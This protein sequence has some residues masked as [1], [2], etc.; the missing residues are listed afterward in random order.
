MRLFHEKAWP[1]AII[2]TFIL[3]FYTFSFAQTESIRGVKFK[4]GS[5]IYGRVIKMNIYDIHIKTKNGKIIS[6]K[7][8]DVDIFIKIPTWMQNRNLNK[9]LPDT[10][11]STPLQPKPHDADVAQ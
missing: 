3:F 5:I 7:F 10:S 4:D 1:C 2:V 9:P 6:R 11:R 8:D